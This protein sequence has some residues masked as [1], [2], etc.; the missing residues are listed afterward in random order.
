[1]KL[2]PKGS[3]S[4]STGCQLLGYT[5]QAYYKPQALE[6]GLVG[7][8]AVLSSI[9]KE[10]RSKCP[11]IGCRAV[12]EN[13]A[14]EIPVGRD[15]F[16]ARAADLDLQ[17]KR[18]RRYIQTTKSDKRMFDNLLVNK[19]VNGINQVWQADMTYYL[20]ADRW[21]FIMLITDVYSQRIV[22]SGAFQ[23]ATAKEFKQVLMQAVRIR[24]K[25]GYNSLEGLIHHSDGGRQYEEYNYRKYCENKGIIQSM[26]FFSWENPY[27]EKSNDLIKGRYLNHWKPQSLQELKV[28]L[29]K[30]VEHHNHTQAKRKLK[31][32]SPIEF[33]W[34]TKNKM[35]NEY[36]YILNL[37]P[38]LPRVKKKAV[39]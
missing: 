11:G 4:I 32:L 15:K 38:A 18:F 26:C 31:G 28:C 33:E 16:E 23:H 29:A 39:I 36:S 13:H 6:K 22:G 19:Q 34:T 30:A 3:V 21:Y 27:A 8:D 35:S 37:K 20:N 25:E 1:M 10:E 9:I 7:L 14:D 12:Y 17:V 24:R 5:R 2:K